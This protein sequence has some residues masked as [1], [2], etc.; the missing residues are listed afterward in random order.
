MSNRRKEDLVGL[1]NP[2]TWPAYPLMPVV[3][4]G[5]REPGSMP[6]CGFLVV[7]HGS[8]VYKTNMFGLKDGEIIPQLAGVPTDEFDSFEAMLDA[9]WECD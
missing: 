6:P 5:E 7:G 4:R 8:K 2:Q 3:N 1:N 9:G